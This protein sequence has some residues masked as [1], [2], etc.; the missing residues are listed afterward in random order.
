MRHFFAALK[1][2]ARKVVSGLRRH[3]LLVPT[4]VFMVYICVVCK[5]MFSWE[6]ALGFVAV[7][8]LPTV[9]AALLTM[10]ASLISPWISVL[11]MICAAAIS[12]TQACGMLGYITGRDEQQL[13]AG[14][15]LCTCLSLVVTLV[16]CGVIGKL[17]MGG[18]VQRMIV[19]FANVGSLI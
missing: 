5:V 2:G 1:T 13:V 7:T 4:I 19:L 10:A 3:S 14:K 16:L 6:L 12:Y 18:V 15:L 17:L 11:L 8:S 9:A